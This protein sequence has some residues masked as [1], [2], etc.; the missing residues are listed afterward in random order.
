MVAYID[1]QTEHEDRFVNVFVSRGD[2][3][4]SRNHSID[5]DGDTSDEGQI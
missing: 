4:C 3:V 1:Q 2:L 5:D